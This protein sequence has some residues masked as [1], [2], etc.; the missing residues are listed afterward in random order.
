MAQGLERIPLAVDSDFQAQPVRAN[1]PEAP[2]QDFKLVAFEPDQMQAQPAPASLGVG[3]TLS[4]LGR[5]VWDAVVYH[6]P[7]AVAA[8]LSTPPSC[9]LASAEIPPARLQASVTILAPKEVWRVWRECRDWVEPR[10]TKSQRRR[11]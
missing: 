6:T 3:D 7:A 9:V 10:D 4:S 11:C 1:F 5:N 8:A 2:S